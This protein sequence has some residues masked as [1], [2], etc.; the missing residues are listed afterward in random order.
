MDLDRAT[1]ALKALE[2]ELKALGVVSV[3]IFGSVARGD[4]GPDSDV[5]VAVRLSE[6]FSRGG[7]DYFGRL[8]DLKSKLSDTLRCRV[9]LVEEPVRRKRLQDE[10]E[11]DRAFAF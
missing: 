6:N 1:E 11:R 8:E 9:D 10:I 7:F 2:P 3:S 4:A 5:D